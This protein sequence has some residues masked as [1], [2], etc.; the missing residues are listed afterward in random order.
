MGH[1]PTLRNPELVDK[2]KADMLAGP[3][4]FNSPEG[5]IAGVEDANGVIHVT[6]GQHR[7]NAA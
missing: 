7:V 3:Y 2:I 6:D 1:T 5:I 4:R